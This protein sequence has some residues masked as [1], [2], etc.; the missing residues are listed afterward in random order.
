MD[1]TRRRP[2]RGPKT[3]CDRHVGIIAART[4]ALASAGALLPGYLR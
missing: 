3:V 1:G 4:A 2:G